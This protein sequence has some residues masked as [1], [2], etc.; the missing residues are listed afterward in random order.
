VLADNTFASPVS[1]RPLELGADLVIHS[2][3]K[4][5]AGHSDVVLGAVV[6]SSEEQQESIRWWANCLGVTA[7]PID[8][9]L[10]L[11]GLRTLR[12][13][14]AAAQANAAAIAELLQ[15]HPAVRQVYYPGL[16]THPG[17]ELAARQQSGFGAIVTF[18]LESL[19]AVEAFLD[20]LRTLC[21]A[22]SL[23]GTESLLC[24]PATMTHS[25]MTP[26]IRAAAGITDGLLRIS[27]GI[28]DVADLTADLEA[29]LE[30]AQS[31]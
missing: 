13:R 25:A 29:A 4:Y 31:A 30:R 20:G 18:E 10:G 24:H 6:T 28:E 16:P 8:C 17:H 14:Y 11:R 2:A 12:L 19:P 22:E 26:E 15:A 23:G 7:G 21:L 5:L 3:T 27:V 1:T 9:Y